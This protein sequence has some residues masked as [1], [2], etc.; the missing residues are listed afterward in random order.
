MSPALAHRTTWRSLFFDSLVI[1]LGVLCATIGLKGFLLSS[2]FIDGGV[3]G[4]SMLLAKTL[5]LP[6]ALL[7]VLMNLPFVVMGWRQMGK[8]FALKT[9][10][11]ILA[12][13][14]CLLWLE[15]PTVTDDK[16]LTAVF[17]GLF[18]G[19]GI[20][21]TIRVGAVLDGTE[22]AALLISKMVHFLRVGDVIL[23]LN[24]G[25]FILA[26]FYL[27]IQPAL[28]SVLTYFAAS[29]TIDFLLHGLEE[30][31]AI[32]IISTQSEAIR[33]AILQ[34]LN[35][36]ATIFRGRRGSSSLEQ[37]IL[38]CIVTRLEIGQIKQTAHLIDES[39]FIYTQSISDIEGGVVKRPRLH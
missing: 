15:V 1:L 12:L 11:A 26:A 28:Y 35:R 24:I 17:G 36:T 6:L 23:L 27:G 25:I 9:F 33:S 39:A 30:Y 10:L 18:I 32:F 7:I 20:G 8:S 37:D 2:H 31:T 4:I 21:L 38:C 3:T 19:A 29:R 16:L 34:E 13:S 5:S 14:A 22:I